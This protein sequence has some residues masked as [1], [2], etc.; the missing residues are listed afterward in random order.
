MFFF[1]TVVIRDLTYVFLLPPMVTDLRLIDS[2]GQGGIPLGFVLFLL[3]IFP[4]LIGKLG[5]LGR[6]RYGNLSLG[7]VPMMIFHCS[8][9]LNFVCSG[10]CRLIS[11]EDL[12]I[13]LL[14]VRTRS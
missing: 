11:L 1:V 12:L 14:Y 6:S 13:G 7:F 9:S 2:S 8:L 5:I 4:N 3:L 10:M